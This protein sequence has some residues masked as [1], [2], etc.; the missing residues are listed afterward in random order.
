MAAR[1]RRYLGLSLLAATALFGPGLWQW[2]GLS[3]QQHRLDRQLAELERRRDALRQEETRLQ[4]DDTYVEGLIRTTFKWAKP[5]EYVI[6]L[7][8]SDR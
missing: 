2:A 3:V 8:S 4:S 7:D 1:T 6:S 5:G